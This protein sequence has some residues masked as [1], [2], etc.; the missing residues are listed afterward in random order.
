M[1]VV[2]F[3]FGPGLDLG[4][5]GRLGGLFLITRAFELG[6]DSR[7]CGL[8]RRL[9]VVLC[10]REWEFLKSVAHGLIICRPSRIPHIHVLPCIMSNDIAT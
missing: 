1:C 10:K 6:L 2:F 3:I 7:L 4:C 9:E 5:V 8:L